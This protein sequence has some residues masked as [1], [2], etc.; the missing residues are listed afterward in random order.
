[1]LGDEMTEDYSAYLIEVAQNRY[2]VEMFKNGAGRMVVSYGRLVDV[3]N[4][5][6]EYSNELKEIR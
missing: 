2:G 5:C 6:S 1:M 3:M 4:F